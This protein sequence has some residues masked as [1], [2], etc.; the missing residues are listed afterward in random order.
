MPLDTKQLCA[1]TEIAA[2]RYASARRAGSPP[3]AL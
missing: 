2:I 3:D 1:N